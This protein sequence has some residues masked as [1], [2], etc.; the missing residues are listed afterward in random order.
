MSTNTVPRY[1]TNIIKRGKWNTTIWEMWKK[2]GKR[3]ETTLAD[4]FKYALSLW[5]EKQQGERANT[6]ER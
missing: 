3:K 4:K 5:I 2:T 6:I 1:L